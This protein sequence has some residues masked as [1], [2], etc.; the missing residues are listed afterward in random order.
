MP[1]RDVSRLVASAL[2]W[3]G[4]DGLRIRV[5]PGGHVLTDRE[6]LSDAGVWDGAWLVFSAGSPTVEPSVASAPSP[7]SASRVAEP[8]PWQAP[9]AAPP[10]DRSRLVLIAGG[11]FALLIVAGIG[12]WLVRPQ[13]APVA[14]PAPVPQLQPTVVPTSAPRLGTAATVAPTANVQA[15]SPTLAPLG[16]PLVI[17]SLSVNTPVVGRDAA[18]TVRPR[19]TQ[20]P[21]SLAPA[22]PNAAPTVAQD[23]AAEWAGVEEQLDALWG[24]DWPGAIALTQAFVQR[25]PGNAAATDK[26]YV[27]LVEYGREQKASD[28]LSAARASFQGAVQLQPDRAEAAVELAVLDGRPAPV[29]QPAVPRIT[30]AGPVS[31]APQTAAPPEPEAPPVKQAVTR[32]N[33]EPP[34]GP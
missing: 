33:Y 20:T 34:P 30:S 25:Y 27:A 22:R 12:V 1:A 26:L 4:A 16:G 13:S 3:P 24:N 7:R 31:S 10:A 5:E 28:Q 32:D 23:P 11:L 6:S 14:A 17:G 18:P 2:G 8:A 19:A 21:F 15:V 29:A 9:A